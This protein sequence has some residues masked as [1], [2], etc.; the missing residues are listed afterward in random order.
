MLTENL[1]F[2]KKTHGLWRT[3]KRFLSFRTEFTLFLLIILELKS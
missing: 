1:R 2:K 3:L